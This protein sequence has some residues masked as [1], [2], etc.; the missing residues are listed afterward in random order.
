[1]YL[2]L[3]DIGYAIKAGACDLD[4]VGITF[5]DLVSCQHT[6]IN[7]VDCEAFTFY[8]SGV[9]ADMCLTHHS[10]CEDDQISVNTDALTFS[11]ATSGIYEVQLSRLSEFTK[12]NSIFYIQCHINYSVTINGGCIRI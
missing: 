12:T 7:E 5:T 1:M 4:Y 2:F 8:M 3:T 10:T 6:C 11:R 9:Y